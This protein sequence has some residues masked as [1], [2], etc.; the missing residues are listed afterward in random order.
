MHTL[1]LGLGVGIKASLESKKTKKEYL[2]YPMLRVLQNP[3][4][5]DEDDN[6][7]I[8]KGINLNTEDL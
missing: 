4:N 6:N 3:N 1:Q 7:G 2:L 8:N 5:D